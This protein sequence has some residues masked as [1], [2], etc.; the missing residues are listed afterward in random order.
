MGSLQALPE[1]V[2]ILDTLPLGP[3]SLERYREIIEGPARVAGLNAE[4]ALVER[5]IHDTATEDALPL[6]A[7]AL[8]QLHEQYGADGVISLSDYQ[9]L[10]DPA[11]GLSP[12]DNALTRLADGVLHAQALDSEQISALAPAF[13]QMCR[14]DEDGQIRRRVARW[15]EIPF[16]IRGDLYQFIGARVLVA[17]EGGIEVAH[18]L[19]FQSWSLLRYWISERWDFLKWKRRVEQDAKEWLSSQSEEKQELLLSGLKLE[20]AQMW[21]RSNNDLI[22]GEIKEFIEAS[23][24]NAENSG[25]ALVKLA[26]SFGLA[27]IV[28]EHHIQKAKYEEMKQQF[29]EIAKVAASMKKRIDEA[30]STLL[31]GIPKVF[32]SYAHEDEEE[33]RKIYRQLGDYGF[34]CWLDKEA[35][36]PGNDWDRE[37]RRAI[38]NTDFIIIVVSR[39]VHGKRGYIQREIR[40]ALDMA[41]EIPAGQAYLIP[42]RIEDCDIPEDI[43]RYHYC[44]LFRDEGAT[45]LVEAM[46]THW[47]LQSQR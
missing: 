40:M 11:A 22:H 30:R 28:R 23:I 27:S 46:L 41:K 45:R 12:L 34:H 35:L 33:A 32:I 37:I 17:S 43:S 14:I 26:G 13:L 47:N 7:F 24:S 38:S 4:P 3:L 39:K 29:N 10:G 18:E 31:A 9:A 25:N 20:R 8:R 21:L 19:L 42:V 16:S 44:D 1:L 5:A 6:L 2:N 15:E 36:L